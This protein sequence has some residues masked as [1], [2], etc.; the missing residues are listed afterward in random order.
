MEIEMLK[1][2]DGK[3][4]QA[5][6]AWWWLRN[7]RGYAEP[8]LWEPDSGDDGGH[9]EAAGQDAPLSAASIATGWQIL[10]PCTPPPHPR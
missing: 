9:W 1:P 7:E 10:G 8:M 2:W 5:N 6:I 3:P 4:P